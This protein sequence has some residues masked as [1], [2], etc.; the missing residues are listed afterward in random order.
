MRRS[1]LLVYAVGLAIL[2]CTVLTAPDIAHTTF[3]AS[4]NVDLPSMTQTTSGL[5]Y[6]DLVVGSGPLLVAGQTVAIHYV[7]NLANGAQFDANNAPATPFSFKLGSGQVIAGFD[8]GIAGMHVGGKRQLVIPASLGY[9]AQAS[10]GIPANS[11]LVFTV[12]VV[13]AQ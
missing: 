8:E 2:G 13:S 6:K 1:P 10:A 9:G 12:D 3:A 11:V 7:G 4:L 5:Y